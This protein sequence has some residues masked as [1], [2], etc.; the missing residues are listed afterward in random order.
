MEPNIPFIPDDNPNRNKLQLTMF[1][2]EQHKEWKMS[3]T[4]GVDPKDVARI[5]SETKNIQS[6]LGVLRRH[7][8]NLFWLILVAYAIAWACGF[9]WGY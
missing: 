8:E 2:L 6:I 5:N 4:G 9:F 7:K 1:D 3:K